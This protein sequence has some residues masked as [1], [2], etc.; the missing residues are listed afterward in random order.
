MKIALSKRQWEFI[1]KQAGWITL[2]RQTLDKRADNGV[3]DATDEKTDIVR[4]IL[5]LS[6]GTM[7]TLSGKKD[8]ASIEE[9][10][11]QFA[12]FAQKMQPQRN[13]RNW[14]DAWQEFWQSELMNGTPL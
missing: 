3:A 2:F 7:A 5:G 12:N 13:W 4:D 10:Q 8:Y 6:S 1:G 9:V 11:N 14:V